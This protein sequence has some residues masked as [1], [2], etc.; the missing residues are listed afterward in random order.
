MTARLAKL[1]HLLQENQLDA[2]LISKPENRRYFSNFT[3]SAGVLLITSTTAQ[4]ITDFR[5][6]EQAA[7]QAT[8]Y[9]IVRHGPIMLEAISQATAKQ[10]VNTMGFETDF[11]TVETYH[12]LKKHLPGMQLT[13][14]KLDSLRMIKDYQEL[15]ALRQAVVIADKAFTH[16]LSFIKPGLTENQV[17]LELEYTMRRLGAEKSAFDIIVAS[18]IRSSLPHGRATDKVIASGDFVT[19]DFGAVYAGYH[20]DITR[21]IVIGKATDRQRE[22]YGIVSQAQLAGV[23]A[24]RPGKTGR[25]VDDVARTIITEAGYG[26]YFGHG[27][28]HG[29]GLVIHEDPRLSPAGEVVLEPGMTVTV[30]PGIYLPD[31]GGVRIEDTV[32]VTTDSCHI[33]TASSKQLIEIV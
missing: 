9:E 15:A 1:R 25:E 8:G 16:I 24:V 4:L 17:A 11:V 5:Y 27:L 30:E 18:G 31:W 2:I 3:G 23:Q 26:A 19:M 13:S 21:T 28:G 12:S 10:H 22:I 32:V 14:V 29:V 6:V 20:S 33:Y 7:R